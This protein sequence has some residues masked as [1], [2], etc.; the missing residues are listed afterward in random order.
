MMSFKLKSHLLFGKFILYSVICT[1]FLIGFHTIYFC[2]HFSKHQT[3]LNRMIMITKRH[4][5]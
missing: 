3:E 5:T 4:I 1:V 2:A